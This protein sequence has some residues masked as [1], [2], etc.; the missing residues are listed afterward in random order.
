[1]IVSG[2]AAAYYLPRSRGFELQAQVLFQ[3]AFWVLFI[4]LLRGLQ[5]HPAKA[6]G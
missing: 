5:L 1:M 3:L 4:R 6:A 2:L